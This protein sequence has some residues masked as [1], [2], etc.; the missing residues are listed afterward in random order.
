MHV[1]FAAGQSAEQLRAVFLTRRRHRLEAQAVDD[2][3]RALQERQDAA[4]EIIR[5]EKLS[6]RR[7]LWMPLRTGLFER[8]L[9]PGFKAKDLM[10]LLSKQ[11][12]Q[13]ITHKELAHLI[14]LEANETL[15]P[16]T[17]EALYQR[18]LI[19]KWPRHEFIS[20]E[21][22]SPDTEYSLGKFGTQATRILNSGMLYFLYGPTPLLSRLG[23]WGADTFD[24]EPFPGRRPYF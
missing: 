18:E 14:G 22:L 23:Q 16:R 20:Q 7:N 4:A 24:Y 15:E 11:K 3:Q 6:E 21:T 10:L 1:Q 2:R 8:E 12:D 9:A 5:L 19:N 13:R 17:F